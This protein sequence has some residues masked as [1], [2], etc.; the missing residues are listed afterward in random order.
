MKDD[1][2]SPCTDRV[3]SRRQFIRGVGAGAFALSL[4]LSGQ[5]SVRAAEA[6]SALYEVGACSGWNN[7]EAMQR[8]GCSYVEEG[9]GKL[10]NPKLSDEEFTKAIESFKA[11]KIPVP[12]CNGFLPG[13]LKLVGPETRHDETVAYAAKAFE[14]AKGLGIGIIVLGSGGAR[15]VPDGFDAQKAEAQ[16]V[17]VVKR[18]AAAAQPFGITVAMESLN[19][20]ETNF[21]NKLRDC[22][23]MAKA[24]DHPNFKLVADFYHMMR[25][26]EGPDALAEAGSMV[27][28]CHV[29]EKAERTP[30]GKAGDDFTPYLRVLKKNGYKGRFSM[31]CRWK[32]FPEEIGPAVA[33]FKKQLAAV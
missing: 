30:P 2:S 12:A 20:G 1:G 26:E 4:G 28:H 22:L 29:A 17:A 10:L 27:V 5:R 14:R 19:R 3:L 33:A 24:V 16:F 23:R 8:A 32:S 25:E 13:E 15:K 6:G 9:V 18:L 7:W 31:E 11:A 21:G